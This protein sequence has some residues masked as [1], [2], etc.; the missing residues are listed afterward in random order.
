[1][2]HSAGYGAQI[3]ERPIR[4]RRTGSQRAARP[5]GSSGPIFSARWPPPTQIL[6]LRMCAAR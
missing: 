6:R 5:G 3:C 2:P 1:M 4:S